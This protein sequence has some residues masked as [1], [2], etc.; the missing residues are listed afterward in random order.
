MGEARMCPVQ[1]QPRMEDGF[2][3][4]NV[5]LIF[6]SRTREIK[7]EKENCINLNPIQVKRFD[8]ILKW[9][10]SSILKQIS[11]VILTGGKMIH[12]LV[13]LF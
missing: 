8:G 9:L 11:F 5:E 3:M 10:S 12:S 13:E 7:K 2:S 6:T 1:L 4:V